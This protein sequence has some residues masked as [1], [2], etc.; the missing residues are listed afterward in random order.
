[1]SAWMNLE[2]INV[3]LLPNADM[4]QGVGTILIIL[5]QNE[6]LVIVMVEALSG[7]SNGS[8]PKILGRCVPV[9]LFLVKQA[10]MAPGKRISISLGD[11]NESEIC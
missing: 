10:V 5:K 6:L 4:L 7:S 1:M 11:Q 9:P 3:W 8:V 2:L